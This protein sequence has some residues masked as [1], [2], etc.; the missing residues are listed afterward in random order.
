MNISDVATA[1]AKDVQEVVPSDSISMENQEIIR[2][3]RIIAKNTA[4][5]V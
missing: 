4:P 1:T 5:K 2:L 3:L